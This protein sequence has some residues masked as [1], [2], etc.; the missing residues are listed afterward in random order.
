MSGLLSLALEFIEITDYDLHHFS[1]QMPGVVQLRNLRGFRITMDN[2]ASMVALLARIRVPHNARMSFRF[3]ARPESY[4][5]TPSLGEECIGVL[6]DFLASNL[7]G[8]MTPFRTVYLSTPDYDHDSGLVALWHNEP[9]S[10][11]PHYLSRYAPMDRKPDLMVSLSIWAAQATE[12]L[13][14]LCDHLPLSE[15][16]AISVSTPHQVSKSSLWH[17]VL[18]RM[19]ETRLLHLSMRQTMGIVYFLRALSKRS[20]MC[21]SLLFPQLE[22][23]VLSDVPIFPTLSPRDRRDYPNQMV[24]WLRKRVDRGL[25]VP[26]LEFKSVL[27][28]TRSDIDEFRGCAEEIMWDGTGR[29]ARHGY[30]EVEDQ[31]DIEPYIFLDSSEAT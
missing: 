6:D 22:R 15:V 3:R 27:N 5:L 16:H 21:P 10:K 26:M 9:A 19:K 1:S 31:D 8:D 7:I 28:L 4:W 30:F 20:D 2:D 23:L 14:I 29:I 24:F 18:R 25:K 11:W 17:G 12:P 13:R